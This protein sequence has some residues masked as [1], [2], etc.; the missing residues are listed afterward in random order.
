MRVLSGAVRPCRLSANGSRIIYFY[1]VRRPSFNPGYTPFT[2]HGVSSGGD[3][4]STFLNASA[5]RRRPHLS[6]STA[7]VH[8]FAA[9]AIDGAGGG[10]FT[11]FMF[12]TAIKF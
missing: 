2:P 3:L 9:D 1:R 5:T 6:V 4:I 8:G 7:F 12:S 10:D 11:F